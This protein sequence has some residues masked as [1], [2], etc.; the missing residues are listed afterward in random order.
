MN[1]NDPVAVFQWVANWPSRCPSLKGSIGSNWWHEAKHY[2]L[3]IAA[4]QTAVKG[5]DR[6]G[7][8]VSSP[9]SLVH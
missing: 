6:P 1:M 2:H 7:S 3:L 4:D 8:L 5:T 9:Q